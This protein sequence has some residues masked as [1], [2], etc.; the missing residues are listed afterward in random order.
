[1]TFP[2]VVPL[3][4]PM[5]PRATHT[6]FSVYDSNKVLRNTLIGSFQ[7]D[8]TTVYFNK[9]HE[10]YQ[11]VRSAVGRTAPF[12]LAGDCERA[13]TRISHRHHPLLAPPSV[14]Q[15]VALVDDHD[16]G[17]EGIEGYLRVSI[18]V[19]GP[20]DKLKVHSGASRF[21]TAAVLRSCP[22]KRVC[23]SH[24]PDPAV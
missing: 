17:D 15:W 22:A 13:R 4:L 7:F 21:L 18:A 11:Q 19:V 1:M 14:L 6:Q 20:G 16:E 10:Y 23:W 8:V 2:L 3:R 12:V 24:G 5:D 9:D